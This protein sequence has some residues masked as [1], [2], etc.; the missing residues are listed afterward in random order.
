MAQ[1]EKRE[2]IAELVKRITSR[3]FLRSVSIQFFES[4]AIFLQKEY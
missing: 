4:L 3:D 1:R 2:T